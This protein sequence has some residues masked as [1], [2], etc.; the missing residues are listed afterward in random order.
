MCV[1]VADCVTVSQTQGARGGQGDGGVPQTEAD[2]SGEE[3]QSHT[4]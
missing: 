2:P 1:Q 4:K 3:A